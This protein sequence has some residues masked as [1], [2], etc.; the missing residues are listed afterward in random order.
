M[1]ESW[2][3]ECTFCEQ[4]READY[5]NGDFICRKCGKAHDA[6]D[7]SAYNPA[8]AKYYRNLYQG[9][10]IAGMIPDPEFEGDREQMR[11]ERW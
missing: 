8:E 6:G 10:K 7:T 4:E 5:K 3:I 1:I 2:L 9:A 11:R